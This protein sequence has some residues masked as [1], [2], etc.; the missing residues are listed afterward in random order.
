MR[1]RWFELLLATDLADV[2]ARYAAVPRAGF[3]VATLAPADFVRAT[4]GTPPPP[5]LLLPGGG[6]VLVACAGLKPYVDGQAA[7]AAAAAA[8]ATAELLRLC[9]LPTLRRC[10]AAAALTGHIEAWARR[11][12]YSRVRLTTQTDMVAAQRLYERRGYA[13]AGT[14]TK[15]YHGDLISL[16]DYEKELGAA[17]AAA[18]GVEQ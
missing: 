15:S 3:W 12:G 17:E 10:G 9:V 5:A 4:G 18:A 8:A 14:V 16:I 11:A 7:D 6:G 2:A 1:T 13:H